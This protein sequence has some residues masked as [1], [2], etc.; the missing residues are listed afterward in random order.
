MQP[1]VLKIIQIVFPNSQCFGQAGASATAAVKNAADEEIIAKYAAEL[2]AQQAACKTK[3][4]VEA[5]RWA[6]EQQMKRATAEVNLQTLHPSIGIVLCR[7]RWCCQS[8]LLGYWAQSWMGH[9]S[10]AGWSESKLVI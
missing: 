9:H 4:K 8:S 10:D 7:E 1:Q 6:A 3:R 5:I 2:K